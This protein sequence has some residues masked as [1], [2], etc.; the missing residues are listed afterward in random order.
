MINANEL[1]ELVAWREGKQE[2]V[3]IAQIKE[4]IGHI[5]DLLYC[6][7]GVLACLVKLGLNRRAQLLKHAKRAARK[8]K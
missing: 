1:A 3:S 4:I 7:P 2:S 6:E 5:A 8:R